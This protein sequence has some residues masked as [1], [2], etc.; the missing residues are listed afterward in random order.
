MTKKIITLLF[1]LG[2]MLLPNAFAASSQGLA[3]GVEEQEEIEYTLDIEVDMETT[4]TT[5]TMDETYQVILTVE[6]LPEIPE[7]I[8]SQND[9]PYP[10]NSLKLKN[11]SSIPSIASDFSS[12]IMILPTGNWTLIDQLYKDSTEESASIENATWINDSDTWGVS[13]DEPDYYGY[14]VTEVTLH[15][16][17]T[18]GVLSYF[19]WSFESSTPGSMSIDYTRTGESMDSTTLILIGVGVGVVV[20][21]IIVIWKVRQ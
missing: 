6:D 7:T 21:I 10:S 17:K 2:F 19:S 11:G 9:I 13:F 12:S 15:Y 20:A 14:G 8:D 1:V 18:D 3:W 4:D 16:S 5:V